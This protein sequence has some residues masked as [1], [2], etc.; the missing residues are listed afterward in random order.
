MTSKD[1]PSPPTTTTTAEPYYAIESR[2]TQGI[3]ILLQRGGKVNIAAAAR[4]F[5]VPEQ[6]LRA[7]WNGRKSKKEAVP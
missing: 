7:R 5:N 4:E 2:I 3:D 1:A 6:R